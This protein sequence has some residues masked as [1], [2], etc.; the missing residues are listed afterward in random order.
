MLSVVFQ[1]MEAADDKHRRTA[2]AGDIVSDLELAS[3]ASALSADGPGAGGGAPGGDG[4]DGDAD[5]DANGRRASLAASFPSMRH[6]NAWLLFRALCKLSMKGVESAPATQADPIAIQSKVLSLDLLLSVLKQAGPAFKT[7]DKFIH[8][9]RQYLC[10]SLLR[11][12]TANVPQV[13]DLSLQVRALPLPRMASA[14]AP[15]RPTY[16]IHPPHPPAHANARTLSLLLSSG[17]CTAHRPLQ[18][19]PQGG[20]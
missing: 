12:C 8:S 6:K 7:S 10:V 5:T 18:G 13:V 19:P 20:D 11:N 3:S 16:P 17:L 1:R 9:I 4:D 15:W 2:S 14:Y